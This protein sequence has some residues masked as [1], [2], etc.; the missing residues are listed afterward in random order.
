VAR[1][2]AAGPLVASRRSVLLLLLLLLLLVCGV[3]G[4]RV[5]EE[6]PGDEAVQHRGEQQRQHEEHPEVEEVDRQVELP[7]HPV[8]AR[9]DGDVVVHQLLDVRQVEPHDAVQ[10]REGPHEQDDLL[11]A[12]QRAQEL[13]FDG[14]ADGDVALDGERGDGARGRVDPQV[15]EV[16][17]AQ[18]PVVAEHPRAEEPVGE[19]RQTGRRQHHEVRHRQTHQVAVGGSP[20]VFGGEHH[21]D[22][23]HVAHDPQR[24]DDQKQHTADHFVLQAVVRPPPQG[25]VEPRSRRGEVVHLGRVCCRLTRKARFLRAR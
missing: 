11:G 19:R 15:L 23:H 18:A 14:V 22:H 10:R 3:G 8:A 24:A 16:G 21:Q 6:D 7:G 25:V 5:E 4:Q 13:R 9:D 12:G 20:H 17:D 1:V 2:L